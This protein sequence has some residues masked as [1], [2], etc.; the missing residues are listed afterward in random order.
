M[1][2]VSKLDFNFQRNDKLPIDSVL[3]NWTRFILKGV[4]HKKSFRFKEFQFD[5]FTE[6]GRRK[7]ISKNSLSVC[8][9]VQ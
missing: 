7:V 5:V 1:T 4:N 9:S 3:S 6:S 2:F 8:F